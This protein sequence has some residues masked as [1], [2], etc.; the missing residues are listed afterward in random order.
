MNGIYIHIPFCKQKCIYCAFYSIAALSKKGVFLDALHNEIDQTLDYLPSRNID[1]LYFGGGTPSLLSINEIESVVEHLSRKYKLS[2]TLEFT[3]EANPEQLNRT[4]L[5][6][7]QSLGVS[8]LSI[9]VQSF[10]DRCLA[11]LGR[12]HSALEAEE[13]VYMAASAG[14]EDI[15][16]DL[17]YGI[18]MRRA[19]E[20]ESDLQKAVKLPITHLSCYALTKEE[21]TLL[22]RKIQQKEI[23]PLDEDQACHEFRQLLTVAREAGFEQ[24]EI[25]NFARKGKIS[26]HN[27][28]YWNQQ[29]YIGLGPSAH[30]Y[31]GDS[32]KWNVSNLQQYID[33]VAQGDATADSE[34]LSMDDRYNE[35]VMVKLRTR[36][37]ISLPYIEK[38]F[39]AE[40]R[41]YAEEQLGNLQLTIDNLQLERGG[42]ELGVRSE[43]LGIRNEELGIRNE[44]FGVRGGKGGVCF[45]NEGERVVLTD[46]GKLFADGI[47]EGLFR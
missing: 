25:S 30:S 39:G 24:Y 1:T 46:E 44:E 19:G 26:V 47:A 16:I 32:R 42:E 5:K 7:L 3:F 2:P 27:S 18:E 29:P 4:Y 9:G 28:N 37:G 21:N 20:W 35:Y 45:Q 34:V 38:T 6:D 22:W 13:A 41:S 33:G 14:F 10:D 40:Y 36:E 31:N 8:R 17:I 23:P 15:S 11:F 43:G 12:K